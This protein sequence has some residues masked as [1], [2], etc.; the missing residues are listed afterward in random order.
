MPHLN[1]ESRRQ[2]FCTLCIH[3]PHKRISHSLWR[4]HQEAQ[5]AQAQLL[6]GIRPSDPSPVSA[7]QETQ[8]EDT[9]N[10]SEST[11]DG[12]SDCECN[13]TTKTSDTNSDS[14][15]EEWN[16]FQNEDDILSNNS[17]DSAGITEPF[18]CSMNGSAGI[19]SMEELQNLSSWTIEDDELRVAIQWLIWKTEYK[20][21]TAAFEHRP[22]G[23]SSYS[24]YR[25]KNAVKEL[26]G[27]AFTKI[28]CCIN[29]CAAPEP[30]LPTSRCPYCN[31]SIYETVEL[32][33]GTVTRARKNYFYFDPLPRLVLDYALPEISKEMQEYVAYMQDYCLQGSFSTSDFRSSTHFS[34]LQAAGYFQ[35]PRDIALLYSMDGVNINR[36]RSHSVWPGVLVNNNLPPELQYRSLQIVLLTPGPKDPLDMGSFLRPLLNSLA[37]LANTGI[38]AYDGHRREEFL[39]KGHL[40]FIS[41]DSPAIAKMMGLKGTNAISHCRYC[42]I[43]GVYDPGSRHYYY[44]LNDREFVFKDT[45]EINHTSEIAMRSHLLEEI[46]Q[47]VMSNNAEVMKDHGISGLSWFWQIPTLAW[48]ASFGLDVM[49]LFSNVA[50]KMWS[51]WCGTVL[52]NV[53]YEDTGESYILSKMVQEQIGHEMARSSRTV[54]VSVSRTPRNINRH[55][56]SF[57]A[58][59]WF[60]W[61]LIYSVPLL[62]GRLQA[63]A[64][65]S[66][67]EYVH[68]VG[69]ALK[70]ELQESDIITMEE[71]FRQF[72]TSTEAIYYQGHTSRLPLLTSQLHGLLH[73]GR[74]IR[75]LG[76]A[77][78]FWQFGLERYVGTLEC[79]AASKRRQ[80]ESMQNGLELQEQI[81]YIH[82]LY[83]L[84][85]A[86]KESEALQKKG[87][88]DLHGLVGYLLG[89]VKKKVL[90]AHA[91]R[92]ISQFYTFCFGQ[93][94]SL[95]SQT[96]YSDWARCTREVQTGTANTFTVSPDS[97]GNFGDRRARNY[98]A[99]STV[100]DHT[101]Y[102]KVQSIIEHEF[103][104]CLAI[105]DATSPEYGISTFVFLLI[106]PLRTST[107]TFGSQ[108]FNTEGPLAIIELSQVCGPIGVVRQLAAAEASA[109]TARNYVVKGFRS[110][111]L[112]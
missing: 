47:A 91:Q 26:S 6:L 86:R 74:S 57:K 25:L 95:G 5:Q 21:S 59:E 51:L 103:D 14:N 3:N 11:I 67:L 7:L 41:G 75:D 28:P 12:D 17:N 92:L 31:E 101:C 111:R 27:L 105:P 32:A 77:Y 8:L 107:D 69:I 43:K 64:L 78:V 50:A 68:A 80:D 1:R 65:N 49:H 40:C 4:R 45:G 61:I 30:L 109:A 56:A 90:S 29:A 100:S 9:P 99:Y 102:G 15:D 55:K 20:V 70:V 46:D 63:Y 76:P 36:Q 62:T 44:P 53:T 110:L 24:F 35:D 52:S 48:P 16:V 106:R 22:E 66:W 89:P 58:T 33:S 37:D 84:P 72:V 60:E 87:V 73:V 38:Q 42:R 85:M 108:H 79:L 96:G 104:A 81:R 19:F 13:S 88:E 93:P 94:I 23:A 18:D 71:H 54:P 82:H 97:R 98:I 112:T 39:L 2:C 34:N 10:G 83:R